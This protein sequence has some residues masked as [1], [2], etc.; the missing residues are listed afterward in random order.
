MYNLT[1]VKP[2]RRFPWSSASRRWRRSSAEMDYAM[3]AAHLARRSAD[4]TPDD[5]S[6]SKKSGRSLL[7]DIQ[8][9]LA[10]AESQATR[11]AALE[12]KVEAQLPN[13]AD[14]VGRLE[15]RLRDSASSTRDRPKAQVSN[16]PTHEAGFA[17]PYA[18]R[19]GRRRRSASI[20]TGGY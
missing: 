5:G 19:A 4:D 2:S 10:H 20:A 13:V 3:D 1:E 16:R 17:R 6:F 12:A 18:R 15:E 8:A 14:G 11:L 9:L 7:S